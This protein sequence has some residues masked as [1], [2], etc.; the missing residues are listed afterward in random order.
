M[1]NRPIELAR[2]DFRRLVGPRALHP[3]VLFPGLV[4]LTLGT[5]FAD[6]Q[7]LTAY[8]EAWVV[9]AVQGFI[10][11]CLTFFA[12]GAPVRFAKGIWRTTGV[13]ATYASTELART[14]VVE[15]A[16]LSRGLIDEVNWFT[17]GTTAILTGM[18]IYGVASLTVN[19]AY[20]F[21]TT[22]ADL[23][24]R[25]ELLQTTLA[26]TELDANI[27]RSEILRSAKSTIRAALEKTLG[28]T[29]ANDTIRS[30]LD[31][32][33]DVV[34]PLSR[35]LLYRPGTFAGVTSAPVRTR[36]QFWEVLDLAS[37]T[38]PFR[39]GATIIVGG[40][41][42]LG[43]AVTSAPYGLGI[44]AMLGLLVV[45]YSL[46]WIANRFLTP[47]LRRM[48]RASRLVVVTVV[49]AI[50][51]GV[52]ACVVGLVNGISQPFFGVFVVYAA[53]LGLLLLWYIATVT[54]VRRGFADVIAALHEVNSQL[55]WAVARVNARLWTDQK[56]LSRILHNEVQG[57][58]V[59]TAFKLQRD[60]DSGLEVHVDLGE[61][62]STIF[63]ALESPSSPTA[64]PQLQQTLADER[65]R[66][67][68]VLDISWDIDES[69]LKSVNEDRDSR[70][71]I[72]DIVG[73]FFT[74]SVKHGQARLATVW[75]R[76]TSRGTIDIS[77]VNDGLPL[78]KNRQPGL[79]TE[80]VYSVSISVRLPPRK[81]G[82]EVRLEIPC[83]GFGAHAESASLRATTVE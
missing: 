7:N 81:T 15:S 47:Q 31:V 76:T 42:A 82:V 58:L 18:T 40:M 45:P 69:T 35:Q 75:M 48:R 19:N 70:R 72:G 44:L 5:A 36:L 32:S 25:S 52:D 65:E 28:R 79:G 60:L 3:V 49:F 16:A 83:E 53:L 20:Q 23:T 57:V 14:F 9:V 38:R 59:A 80:L 56:E 34:R 41:L 30:L 37:S 2:A 54:G 24:A 51:C 63:A 4:L 8:N 29:S 11:A 71:V 33:D 12:F 26:R 13:L 1:A 27:A 64:M 66:W 61:I 21:R 46:L 77:L 10:A 55:E 22:V 67:Q 6:T 50:V 73:E 39:P 43:S 74:N 62:R 17:Q 78:P 68:H